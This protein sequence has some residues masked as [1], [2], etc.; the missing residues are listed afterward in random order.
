VDLIGV[1]HIGGEFF[2]GVCHIER[3][4]FMG[5]YIDGVGLIG[6]YI[7]GVGLIGVCHIERVGFIGTIGAPMPFR[8]SS[9]PGASRDCG[10]G[11]E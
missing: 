4:G 1:R 8:V 10:R 7:D 5:V 9:S 6:V 11:L 3:V 2:L